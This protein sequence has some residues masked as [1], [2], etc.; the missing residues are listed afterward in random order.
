MITMLIVWV[1]ASLPLGIIVGSA[2]KWGD[3]R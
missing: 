1:I 2:I 3:G